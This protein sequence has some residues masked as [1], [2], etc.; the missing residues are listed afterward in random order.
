MKEGDR[1]TIWRGAERQVWEGRIVRQ[2]SL[3]PK[4]KYVSID[5]VLCAVLTR[6][7]G[8]EDEFIGFSFDIEKDAA[9]YKQINSLSQSDEIYL[10]NIRRRRRGGKQCR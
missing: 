4:R 7:V 8:D 2:D 1:V 10:P 5:D 9:G 6:K 3:H